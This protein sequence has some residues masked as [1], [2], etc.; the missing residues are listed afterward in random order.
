MYGWCTN[1]TVLNKYYIQIFGA[2]G[3]KLQAI[4]FTVGF[5]FF[6]LAEVY[7]TPQASLKDA[8]QNL[9]DQISGLEQKH[10]DSQNEINC[11]TRDNNTLDHFY[12]VF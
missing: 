2:V 5:P 3:T 10:P 12:T 1:V 6:I 9:A 4:L 11:P 8:Q 7:I